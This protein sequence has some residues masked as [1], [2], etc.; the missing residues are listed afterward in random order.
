MY[1]I[2]YRLDKFAGEGLPTQPLN[3]IT[4]NS[5]G[6]GVATSQRVMKVEKPVE[7][8][9]QHAFLPRFTDDVILVQEA[10]K[11]P[12]HVVYQLDGMKRV[13]SVGVEVKTS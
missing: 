7:E 3:S 6:N 11:K 8:W 2:L 1:L 4:V 13:T 5:F 9:E 10:L 12:E